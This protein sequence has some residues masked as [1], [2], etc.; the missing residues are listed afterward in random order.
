[1]TVVATATQPE[2]RDIW[3]FDGCQPPPKKSRFW[4]GFLCGLPVYP[5]VMPW[6]IF[7]TPLEYEAYFRLYAEYVRFVMR[8]LG[9]S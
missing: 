2:P 5:L 1:M 8:T 7:G 3:A 9:V 6:V 4:L